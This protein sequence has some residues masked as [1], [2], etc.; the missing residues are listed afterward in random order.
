MRDAS[1]GA[2]IASALLELGQYS[3]DSERKK[4]VDSAEKMLRSLASSTYRAK[5]GQNGGFLLMH[6]VG[7]FTANSEVDTPLTYADYYFLEALKRYK[8]WYLKK[9]TEHNYK[10]LLLKKQYLQKMASIGRKFLIFFCALLIQIK[11]QSLLFPGLDDAPGFM[12]PSSTSITLFFKSSYLKSSLNPIRKVECTSPLVWQ[13]KYLD[14]PI[15]NETGENS[16]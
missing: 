4:Y 12:L 6:S 16:V 7:H 9:I 15:S 11:T 2:I 10:I 8:D 3:A 13:R 14:L 5:L 1:A